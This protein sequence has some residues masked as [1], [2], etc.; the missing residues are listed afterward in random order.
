M[1]WSE[2]YRPREPLPQPRHN[3]L[4]HGPPGTGKTTYALR[5]N[6]D[7]ELNASSQRG[8]NTI[9][10]LNTNKYIL[11]DECDY[12][13]TDAQNCLRRVME[14]GKFIL[15]A[16]YIS[17]LSLPL[18]SRVQTI[19]FNQEN[20]KKHLAEIIKLENLDVD[21]NFV[22]QECDGD[23]RRCLNILQTYKAII[24][25]KSNKFDDISLSDDSPNIEKSIDDESDKTQNSPNI[26]NN[27]ELLNYLLGKIPEETIDEFLTLKTKNIKFFVF[28]FMKSA[29]IPI[30]LINS[31]SQYLIKSSEDLVDLAN[32]LS[33][34]EEMSLQGVDSEI[35]LFWMCSTW[36]KQ[37]NK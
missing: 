33:E 37:T 7:L 20:M 5:L 1:L 31:L 14:K 2:K 27:T 26:E 3:L 8:I 30:K 25:N 17:K 34:G 24:T 9:R 10:G 4:L 13:T 15:C 6:P 29:Y 35:L 12:L 11:L 21:L 22:W 16:N 19:K 28:N 18:R 23:I 32:I 36:C